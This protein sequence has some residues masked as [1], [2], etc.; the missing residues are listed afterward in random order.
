[1]IWDIKI[2]QVKHKLGFFFF[3]SI[4]GV[5]ENPA[6]RTSVFEAVCTLNSVLVSPFIS[7]G[8]PHHTA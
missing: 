7:R 8:A 2:I 4:F 6:Y 1:M 5:G 3:S